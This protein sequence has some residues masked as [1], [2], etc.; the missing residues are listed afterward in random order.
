MTAAVKAALPIATPNP[1]PDLE[2]V[3]TRYDSDTYSDAYAPRLLA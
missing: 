2:A 1:T 3:K